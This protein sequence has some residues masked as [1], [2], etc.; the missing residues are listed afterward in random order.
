MIG[1]LPEEKKFS[2]GK[3]ARK[4]ARAAA[5]GVAALLGQAAASAALEW[6]QGRAGFTVSLDPELADRAVRLIGG[7]IAAGG[8]GVAESVRN[9]I[10]FNLGKIIK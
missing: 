6:A 2:K 10:K 5:Y 4:G 7:T 1:F 8:V 3:N 9:W